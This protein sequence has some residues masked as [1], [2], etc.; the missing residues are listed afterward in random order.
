MLELSGR[1]FR[2]IQ[3]STI[4]HDVWMMARSAQA[5]IQR[6]AM[7]DDETPE[8]FAA[9]LTGEFARSGQM[10]HLLAGVLVPEEIADTDWT[11]AIA[12]ETAAFLG[13]ITDPSDKAVVLGQVASLVAGFFESGLMSCTTSRSYSGALAGDQPVNSTASPIAAH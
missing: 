10:L 1:R 9:R 3:T 12:A 4:E 11:P 13:G 8:A 7:H 5:G 6:V 2:A